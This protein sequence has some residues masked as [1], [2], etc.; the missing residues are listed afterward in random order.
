MYPNIHGTRFHYLECYSEKATKYTA[1]QYLRKL[2]QFEKVVGFG[3]SYPDLPLVMACD[4][5]YAVSNAV[6]EVKAVSTGI[7]G[8]NT[9]D[10][11]AKWL[12]V[13]FRLK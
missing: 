11:V 1:T 13:N 5:F 2:L 12:K 6:N 4:E 7:I 9:T 3:D 8:D 10:S